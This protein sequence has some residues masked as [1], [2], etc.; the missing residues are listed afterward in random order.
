MSS[1]ASTVGKVSASRSKNS[2]Q[3]AK[4]SCRSPVAAP[5]RP[6]SCASARLDEALAR[7]DRGSAPPASPCSFS[8]AESACLVLADP[9]A[10]P[11]HVGERPVGDA[12]PVGEAAAAVPVDLLDDPV[13]VLVELPRQPRLADPRDPGHRDQ[14]RPPLLGAAVE[15]LLASASAPARGRRTAPPAPPTS[16]ARSTP[17]R[18]ATRATARP[19]PPSPSARARRRSRTRSPARSRAASPPRP[20]PSPAQPPTGSARRC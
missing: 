15:E 18:R 19:A 11:H 14:M 6:S 20:A 4:R 16:A 10:H 2:R 3:A 7:P 8:R 5:S 17:R 9:A 1:K 13:E 12:L